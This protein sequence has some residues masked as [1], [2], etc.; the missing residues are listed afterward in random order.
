MNYKRPKEKELFI[1]NNDLRQ[2]VLI[3]RDE[4]P[5]PELS[6]GCWAPPDVITYY[7]IDWNNPN[8]NSHSLRN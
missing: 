6:P 7:H 8:A 4:G 5:W 2:P 3:Y 1:A